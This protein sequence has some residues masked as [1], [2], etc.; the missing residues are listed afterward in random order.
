M[1]LPI[2]RVA[3][4]LTEMLGAFGPDGPRTLGD[5]VHGSLNLE[6]FY[7]RQQQQTVSQQ[8]TVAESG[9]VVFGNTNTNW[10]YVTAVSLQILSTATMTA[11]AGSIGF[12]Q[13]VSTGVW[14]MLAHGNWNDGGLGVNRTFVVCEWV[15]TFP[16]LM[17]PGNV[18][19]G[20][21]DALGADPT[22]QLNLNV[23][24]GALG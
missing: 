22:A 13:G 4:G 7:A 14:V 20:R 23:L 18:L 12:R 10:L 15:P 6:P 8:A 16:F 3:R 19:R 5:E 24:F 17:A 11:Y 21:L 1:P 9:E 2:Q